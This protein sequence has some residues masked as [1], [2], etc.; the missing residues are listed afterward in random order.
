MVGNDQS[1]CI[2]QAAHIK[3]W[4]PQAAACCPSPHSRRMIGPLGAR[5]QSVP[6]WGVAEICGGMGEGCRGRLHWA[7]CQSGHGRRLARL[8]LESVAAT[9]IGTPFVSGGLGGMTASRNRWHCPGAHGRIGQHA[10]NYSKDPGHQYHVM[11]ARC[12][13]SGASR[14]WTMT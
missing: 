2:S 9:D 7:S 5:H 1:L 8:K 3:T 13:L 11:P 12:S 6:T 14:V 10:C 4:L